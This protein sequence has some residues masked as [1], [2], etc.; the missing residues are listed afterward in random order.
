MGNPASD[1]YMKFFFVD[2]FGRPPLEQGYPVW[3]QNHEL[4]AHVFP[5]PQWA[6]GDKVRESYLSIVPRQ[7]QPGTYHLL[8]QLYALT[9]L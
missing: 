9:A 8:A 1:L 5:T 6:P 7:V 4:G 3:L 2:S